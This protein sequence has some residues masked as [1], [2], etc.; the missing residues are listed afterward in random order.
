MEQNEQDIIESTNDTETTENTE[1]VDLEVE[2]EETDEPSE[3]VEALKKK[4]ATTEAQKEHWRTKAQKTQEKPVVETQAPAMSLK[5]SVALINAK[6]HEDDIDEVLDYAKYKK[7]SIAEALKSNV[8]KKS[9]AERNEQ[10]ATA[11][12]TNTSKSRGTS[13]RTSEEALLSK[14]KKTGEIPESE[15]DLARMLAARYTK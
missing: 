10:R 14:A 2:A 8:V 4:L 1:V 3:D 11:E 12:A 6:V 9:L 13:S 15:D 5:D 7:I